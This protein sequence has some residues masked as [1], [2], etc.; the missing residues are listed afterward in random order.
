MSIIPPPAAIRVA[1]SGTTKTENP[2][3]YNFSAK[4]ESPDVLPAQGP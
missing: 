1:T 3:Y 4:Y 2:S